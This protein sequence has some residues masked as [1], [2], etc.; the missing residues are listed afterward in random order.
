MAASFMVSTAGYAA[1]QL[2]LDIDVVQ[3]FAEQMKPE[4]GCISVFDSF[5]EDAE[6]VTALTRRGLDYLEELIDQRRS[7]LMHCI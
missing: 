3:D 6:S 2:G 7:D 5:A 4:D 1:S